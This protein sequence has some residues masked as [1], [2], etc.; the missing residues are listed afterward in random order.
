MGTIFDLSVLVMGCGGCY[1]WSVYN[2]GYWADLSS[3]A[4]I[5]YLAGCTYMTFRYYICAVS[6]SGSG[7][8]ARQSQVISALKVPEKMQLLW[9]TPSAAQAASL[10]PSLNVSFIVLIDIV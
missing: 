10:L 2:G 5:A 6:S 3:W 7:I 4:L 8:Y 1:V 9:T